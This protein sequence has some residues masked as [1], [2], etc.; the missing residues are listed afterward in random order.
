MERKKM[1]DSILMSCLFTLLLM[2]W[3]IAP[4]ASASKPTLNLFPSDVTE[5]L[6]NTGTVAKKM[7]KSLKG[8]IQKLDA[9][10]KLYEET[11]CDGSSEPGCDELAKQMGD[12]YMEILTIMKEN[13][14]EMK[15]SIT[16]TNK[17]IEKNIRREVGKKTSPADIQRL[18][19]KNGKPKVFKGKYSLS[20]RFA[21][22]HSMISRGSNNTLATLA[23]EIYLDSREVLNMIGLMEAE[24]AQQETMIKL[25]QMYGTLT[26]QMVDTVDAVKAV[27]FGEVEEEGSLPVAGSGGEVEG[28]QSP[29]EMD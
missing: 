14:P 27:I 2:V 8:T 19:G 23:A 16:A 1:F 25:G 26:P 22:Y 6:S 4:A 7:E 11:G 5:Q 13:L 15:Q 20:S 18:L 9:Q 17:G 12:N 24:I 29:L 10:K 3:G 21:Q 28:F